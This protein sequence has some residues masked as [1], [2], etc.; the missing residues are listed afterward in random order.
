MSINVDR[1]AEYAERTQLPAAQILT[2]IL[3]PGSY[4]GV[5]YA[6]DIYR[7][8][9]SRGW[10]S[11]SNFARD[12]NSQVKGSSELSEIIDPLAQETDRSLKQTGERLI[13]KDPDMPEIVILSRM[14][15]HELVDSKPNEALPTPLEAATRAFGRIERSYGTATAVSGLSQSRSLFIPPGDNQFLQAADEARRAFPK[16]VARAELFGEVKTLDEQQASEYRLT[17]YTNRLHEI[18]IKITKKS[19]AE[20]EAIAGGFLIRGVTIDDEHTKKYDGVK[21]P[22]NPALAE[23]KME[24][25]DGTFT[26]TKV[27]MPDGNYGEV[28]IRSGN[29]LASWGINSLRYTNELIPQ[30]GSLVKSFSPDMLKQFDERNYQG[31]IA[32]FIGYVRNFVSNYYLA[33]DYEKEEL[34]H[35]IEELR[36]F[37]SDPQA[38]FVEN[39]A[40][41][42][43]VRAGWGDPIAAAIRYQ[44]VNNPEFIE[45][46]DLLSGGKPSLIPA[47]NSFKDARQYSGGESSSLTFGGKEGAVKNNSKEEIAELEGEGLFIVTGPAKE[48]AKIKSLEY[49]GEG[50]D[51]GDFTVKEPTGKIEDAVTIRIAELVDEPRGPYFTNL[52]APMHSSLADL[53]ITTYPDN[54]QGP[55]IPQSGLHYEVEQSSQGFLRINSLWG[56]SSISYSVSIEDKPPQKELPDDLQKMQPKVLRDISTRLKRLGYLA[57]AESIESSLKKNKRMG[58]YDLADCIQNS[59]DYSFNG[60]SAELRYLD[61]FADLVNPDTGRLEYQCDG[62]QAL[63]AYILRFY[64][65]DAKLRNKYEI[66]PTVLFPADSSKIVSGES[67]NA[68]LIVSKSAHARIHITDGKDTVA[69]L[70][71]TPT[72]PQAKAGSLQLGASVSGEEVKGSLSKEIFAPDLT[73]L[74]SALDSFSADSSV[75]RAFAGI[76]DM[77]MRYFADTPFLQIPRLASEIVSFYEDKSANLEARLVEIEQR[78]EAVSDSFLEFLDDN[79]KDPRAKILADGKVRG[80]L[81]EI[82]QE[83]RKVV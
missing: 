66:I 25:E 38:Y 18:G 21:L 37:T 49:P 80:V 52:P 31:T 10:R 35:V 26:F 24:L 20:S 15:L 61:G 67:G 40:A 79:V 47:V 70:D 51:H 5:R 77:Q 71:T 69:I 14:I 44:I 65:A 53:Q 50:Y 27:E 73:G 22:F 60:K 55:F 23:G 13:P 48:I 39:T 64:F 54:S 46:A 19:L 11:W 56:P 16:E 41:R 62:A 4:S 74:R 7:F 58:L 63:T 3:K 34:Q 29:D 32:F 75:R 30:S 33:K 43:F 42:T 68:S 8:Q 28:S 76:S 36:L 81:F 1:L 78:F 2:G 12:M 82:L 6:L 83:I 45:Q 72:I 57:L 17:S 59:A 9:E